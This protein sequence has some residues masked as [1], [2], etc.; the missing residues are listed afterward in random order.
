MKRSCNWLKNILFPKGLCPN[1]SFVLFSI[2]FISKILHILL[3]KDVISIIL[4][5][6]NG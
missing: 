5:S 1:G 3:K 6:V 4:S 2:V